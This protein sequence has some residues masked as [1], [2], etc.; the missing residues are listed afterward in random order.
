MCS[1]VEDLIVEE[2]FVFMLCGDVKNLF[3]GLMLIDFVY[4]VYIDVG[5]C[6]VGVK[7]NG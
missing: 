6:V 7:V 2:V 1:F 4:V 3:V 5:Y